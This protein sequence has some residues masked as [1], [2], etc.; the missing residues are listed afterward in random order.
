MVV[1][2]NFIEEAIRVVKEE[3]E[4]LRILAEKMPDNFEKAVEEIYCS[5][6][7]LVI[8]GIGKS[9][10][11]GRKISSTMSSIGQKSFFMHPSEAHHGDLGMLDVND[12]ILAISY[13]GESLEILPV[14]DYSKRI[15]CK[16]ISITKNINS[17]LAKNTDIVLCLPNIKEA[18]PLGI[19]PTVSSTMTLALGDALSVALLS[20]RGFTLEQFKNL[21]PGGYIG[22]T[23]AFVYDIM[24]EKKEIPLVYSG[25]MMKDAIVEM[26][27]YSLGCVGVIDNNGALIGIITDGDLRRN[28]SLDL[29]SKCVDD[30]M[31]KNPITINKNMLVSELLLLMEKKQIT[32]VFVL[33]DLENP[34]GAVHIHDMLKKKIV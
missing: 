3:S 13:S 9:G 30:I 31:T 22:Q 16:T 12:I 14:I 23:L 5:T 27:K 15:G 29:L 34:I 10:H 24:H 26:T 8:V 18:C 20:R 17:S 28:M 25:S 19:A 4:A 32:C 1:K 33:D 6:G 7:R 21:H 2:S 11:I